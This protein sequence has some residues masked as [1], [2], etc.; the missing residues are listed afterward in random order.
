MERLKTVARKHLS[1]EH[2]QQIRHVVEKCRGVGFSRYCPCCKSHLRG[3]KPFGLVPR[4]DAFCPV[5]GSLERH[6][7]AYVYVIE[8]TD[9]F[10]GR[11]KEMLHVAPEPQLSRLFQKAD[12]IE[13]LSADLSSPHAMVS[14]DVT[15]IQYPDEAFDVIFCSHVLE[16]VLDDT[17]AMRELHRVLKRGG[18]AILQVPIS[19]EA[20]FED[21]T[22]TRPEERERL[23]GQDD[24]VRRYG[25][26]YKDRLAAAGF[27]VAVDGFVRELDDRTVT[28]FGLMPDEDIYFCRKE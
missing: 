27:S 20:T 8:K 12:Y 26:D 23:F 11:R 9:L 24:H 3:F 22:V 13:Y 7:L 16:H 25:P 15:D 10:D 1:Y 2:R 21:P 5:C 4:P 28:R 14:M 19:A 18:W 6:R 17:K